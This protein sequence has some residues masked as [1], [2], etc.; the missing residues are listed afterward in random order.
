MVGLPDRVGHG[1][2]APQRQLEAVAVGG[3]T[4]MR[5]REQ[6]AIE[7]GDDRSSRRVARC[8]PAAL[9]CQ[10]ADLPVHLRDRRARTPQR[11]PLDQ[12]NDLR[13]RAACAAVGPRRAREAREAVGA[14]ASQP[15]PRGALGHAGLARRA[16]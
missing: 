6:A 1:G 15:A 11:E 12:C 2:L 13:W 7:R 9:G 5:E 14:E 3:R 10:P 8:R 16:A 4:L